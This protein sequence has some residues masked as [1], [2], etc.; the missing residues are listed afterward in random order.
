MLSLNEVESILALQVLVSPVQPI[1]V[2]L[3]QLIL[4]LQLRVVSLVILVGLV[5]LLVVSLVHV[6]LVLQYR[7]A[8][9]AILVSP[10]Q[11]L[12]VSRCTWFSLCSFGSSVR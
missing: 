7:I 2:S 6:V 1:P 8:N 9:L 11:L 5:Q 12:L 10:V 3:A 4:A